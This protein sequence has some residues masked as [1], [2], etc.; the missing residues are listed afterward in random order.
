MNVPTEKFF[1]ND[2]IEDPLDKGFTKKVGCGSFVKRQTKESGYSHFEGTWEDLENLTA[3]GLTYSDNSYVPH[4]TYKIHPGYKDGVIIVDLDPTN[5]RSAIVELDNNS[6]LTANYAP[7]RDGEAPYIRVS[8]KDKK[9]QA[10]FASVVLYRWDVLAE[11]NERETTAIW[12]IV[13][14]KARVSEGE[15]PMDPY[16]M[17]R[18]FLHLPGGTKG[19]FTAEQF[20]KSIVYWNSHC[21]TTSSKSW[22]KKALSWIKINGSH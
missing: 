6:K 19:D 18:N 8:A 16:T 12:E 13:A 4:Y 14:I 9:K 7:R 11:N 21:M 3:I 2:N 1:A 22:F 17:A 15:E 5:F 20:A 10:K